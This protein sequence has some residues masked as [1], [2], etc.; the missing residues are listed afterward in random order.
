[1]LFYFLLAATTVNPLLIEE[2]EEGTLNDPVAI[3]ALEIQTIDDTQDEEELA[4][5][6]F[7]FKEE[8]DGDE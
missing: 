1:M 4:V 2:A 7:D 8:Y 3:E 5:F 6:D